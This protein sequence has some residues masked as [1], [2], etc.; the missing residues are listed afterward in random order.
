MASALAD[1]A[2]W[3]PPKAILDL[4]LAF[5]DVILKI[6]L[7]AIFLAISPIVVRHY[8]RNPLYVRP[9]PLLW[10]KLVCPWPLRNAHIP[11]DENFRL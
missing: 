3:P 5:E 10:T 9:S 4:T 7:S 1:Q 8:L 11:T 6:L 2:F